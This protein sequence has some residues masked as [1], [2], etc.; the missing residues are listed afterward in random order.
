[1]SAPAGV[2]RPGSGPP[3]VSAPSV[4]VRRSR[5][6]RR[7]VSAYRDGATI[8][9]LIP[10]RFTRAQESRWV[11]DMVAD[12]TAREQRARRRGARC[13][14]SALLARAA[15]LNAE[16]LGGRAEASSVRWVTTMAQRWASCTPVDRTVRVSARLR[17]HPDWVLDYVLVHELAHLLVAGHGPEFWQLVRR[18]ARAERARGYL[19]GLSAAARASGDLASDSVDG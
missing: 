17:E 19:E 11:A 7:T 13:G 8:V 5:R 15:A 6:R 16:Y 4:E 1:M 12:V 2:P 18:Y 9:V 3:P 10:D 14:D